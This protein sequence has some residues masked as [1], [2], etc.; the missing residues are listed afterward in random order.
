MKNNGFEVTGSNTTTIIIFC[1]RFNSGHCRNLF[2]DSLN[3][4]KISTQ[5]NESVDLNRLEADENAIEKLKNDEMN[6]YFS[7]GAD[8]H[9]VLEFHE[10]RGIKID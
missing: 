4:W 10:R 6:N 2:I 3:R 9:V 7:I 8:A 1:N 5:P